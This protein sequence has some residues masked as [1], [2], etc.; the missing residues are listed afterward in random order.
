MALV[1]C[2]LAASPGDY[3]GEP[4]VTATDGGATDGTTP[5]G[6]APGID[7]AGGVARFVLLSGERDPSGPADNPATTND[8]WTAFVDDATGAV[9]SYRVELSALVRGSMEFDAVIGNTWVIGGYGYGVEG[10]SKSALQFVGWGPGA[11]TDWLVTT[12]GVPSN[13]SD[14]SRTLVGSTVVTVGGIRSYT[15]DGGG[16]AYQYMPD[17]YSAP[18]DVAQRS[19]ADFTQMPSSLVKGRSRAGLY[20][21]DNKFIY[22]VGGKSSSSTLLAD[23]EAAPVDAVA[24]T[25]GTFAAQP[26]LSAP[27]TAPEYKI[28][29]PS[30]T[31]AKGYLYVA[32]G[33]LNTSNSPSDIVLAAKINDADGS[34]GD[35]KIVTK[36][37][38]PTR[39]FGFAVYKDRLYVF[40]G[41]GATQ[42]SD[43]VLTAAV[44]ADGELGPWESAPNAKLP[45]PRADIRVAAY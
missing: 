36:L 20:V 19:V 45:A 1:A 17:L 3:A 15:P 42:R 2:G 10:T 22:V 29:D 9:V 14:L 37:P 8:V 24:G 43:E 18:V 26:G 33:R 12:L 31:S 28:F 44:L 11:K 13:R 4:V 25:V 16:T 40:G 30:V 35:W 5:D 32:G 38:A 41:V 6:V 21:H 23:V 7:A 34:L 39:D 27:P